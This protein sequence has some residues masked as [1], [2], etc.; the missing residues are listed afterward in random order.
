MITLIK[1][2]DGT[3]QILSDT[4]GTIRGTKESIED[5]LSL[6]FGLTADEIASYF[7]NI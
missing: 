4:K 2:E 6:L 7:K 5:V 3:Y 1:L